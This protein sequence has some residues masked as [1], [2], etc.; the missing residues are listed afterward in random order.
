[1]NKE[2]I[3]GLKNIIKSLDSI[4]STINKLLAKEEPKATNEKKVIKKKN[5]AKVA[6]K[7]IKTNKKYQPAKRSKK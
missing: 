6:K 2:I 3:S 5:Q 4:S 7:K 1:M